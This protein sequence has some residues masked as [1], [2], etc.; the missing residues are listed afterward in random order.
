MASMDE[1]RRI[2]VIN[3]APVVVRVER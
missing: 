1:I 3:D 2:G